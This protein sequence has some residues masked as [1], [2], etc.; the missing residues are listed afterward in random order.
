MKPVLL[1]HAEQPGSGHMP[2][3]KLLSRLFGGESS[4]VEIKEF[5]CEDCGHTFESAKQPE[6]AQCMDCL[7]GDVRVVGDGD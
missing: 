3:S 5:E 6:R 4:G 1:T 2:L 7:S